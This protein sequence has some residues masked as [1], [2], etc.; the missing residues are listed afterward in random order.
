[1]LGSGP[2]R[3]R[4]QSL[5]EAL[6][7][8]GNVRFEGQIPSGEMPARLARLHLLVL[9]SHTRSNWMEQFGRILIEAMISG[10]PVVGSNSGEIPNVIGDA[11]L[12][13]P[14]GEVSTLREHIHSL[15]VDPDL[16]MIYAQLG[17]DRVHARYTQARIAAETVEV[18]RAILEGD[19]PEGLT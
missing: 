8:A 6:G 16:W 2:E 19:L 11:G 17:R 5:A 3:K 10:V 1:M 12:V 13:Y 18:Y 14:E 9:P 4:L 7:I 15:M